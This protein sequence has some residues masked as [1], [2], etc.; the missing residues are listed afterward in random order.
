MNE[1]KV[2]G[3]MNSNTV[4]QR[5]T[6]NYGYS[7][8]I[9][10]DADLITRLRERN[11]EVWKNDKRC[12]VTKEYTSEAQ[13][14]S[15]FVDQII[16]SFVYDSIPAKYRNN[17]Y[18]LLIINTGMKKYS[19]PTLNME[20]EKDYRVCRKYVIESLEDLKR[21]PSLNDNFG[22]GIIDPL[23]FDKE[24]IVNLNKEPD[25]EEEGRL[26]TRVREI[27]DVYFKFYDMPRENKEEQIK[28][29]NQILTSEVCQVE[30]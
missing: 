26:S 8:I 3:F 23:N 25:N 6:N 19:V 22:Q 30:N 20:I 13:L 2:G 18:F 14:K 28:V 1:E 21:V 15:W 17:L 24:F 29:I 16:I 11:L 7:E 12:M 9:F 5:L 27:V 10:E 4:L